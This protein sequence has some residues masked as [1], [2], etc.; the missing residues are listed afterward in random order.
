M[1]KREAFASDRS[2]CER[3]RLP[4]MSDVVQAI[5]KRTVAVFP[6]FPPRN[7]GQNE[8][9]RRRNV[10]ELPAEISARAFFRHM[11]RGPVM[12][13]TIRPI[14]ETPGAEVKFRRVEI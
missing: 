4:G 12:I 9:N 3:E 8:D 13:E 11:G 2:S 6:G 14:D 7:A 10:D 1:A 5:P